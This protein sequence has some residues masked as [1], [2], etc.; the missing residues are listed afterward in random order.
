MNHK[1]PSTLQ[2]GFRIS[3]WDALIL[4]L[5]FGL[6]WWLHS[7]DFPLWWVVP[8][9]LGYWAVLQMLPSAHWLTHL[10]VAG[11]LTATSVGITAR[12]LKDLGMAATREARII[13]GAAVADDVMGLVVM[14]V[15]SGLAAAASKGTG[16]V[17]M[18]GVA[19]IIAKA[20]GFLVVAVV[21]GVVQSR[22]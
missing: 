7:I 13:L 11:T 3:I 10:F 9:A 5:G 12:V 18:A 20:G 15:I 19:L 2:H 22:A 14:A 17:D 16:S 21:A 4:S 6:T 1:P 8:M